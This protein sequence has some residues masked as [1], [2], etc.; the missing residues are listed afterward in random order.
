MD[1]YILPS[2]IHEIMIKKDDGLLTAE[3]LKEIVYQNNRMEV[4][5][6]QTD[7]LSDNVY[8]YSRKTKALR[9]V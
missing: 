3:E 4:I 9:I 5:V 6:K 2:S 8:H 1:Y 7:V